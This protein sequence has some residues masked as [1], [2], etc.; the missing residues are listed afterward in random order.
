MM[1]VD[2]NVKGIYALVHHQTEGW[3]RVQRLA[4]SSVPSDALRRAATAPD[5][6]NGNRTPTQRDG[7]RQRE[8]TAA[9]RPAQDMA[10]W[11][12][13]VLFESL[14]AKSQA[15]NGAHF[16]VSIVATNDIFPNGTIDYGVIS[17][18]IVS[19]SRR[20]F[21][22]VNPA[23]NVDI[24]KIN[25]EQV[26]DKDNYYTAS[27][28]TFLDME[29]ANLPPTGA[30]A[31][32]MVRPTNPPDEGKRYLM[33]E[34]LTK[35]GTVTAY[36][37]DDTVKSGAQFEIFGIAMY[38]RDEE[39][40]FRTGVCGRGGKPECLVLSPEEWGKCEG[41]LLAKGSPVQAIKWDS[42]SIDSVD[43]IALID[44]PK[45]E[46]EQPT[47]KHPE[48]TQR[49]PKPAKTVETKKTGDPRASTYYILNRSVSRICGR[50]HRRLSSNNDRDVQLQ[51]N[52]I[53]QGEKIWLLA[54]PL[55]CDA[56]PWVMGWTSDT[57][58]R[59]EWCVL[60]PQMNPA[61]GTGV[62]GAPAASA[63][64]T[65]VRR[66]RA[67]LAAIS[68]TNPLNTIQLETTPDE[69]T[70]DYSAAYSCAPL[71]RS[72]PDRTEEPILVRMQ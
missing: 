6:P 53:K 17:R 27:K 16:E 28:H 15:K 69:I 29:I 61:T 20:Y 66:D 9:R 50:V 23:T 5:Q 58:L 56:D 13:N 67:I 55:P 21:F 46:R 37:G 24:S 12:G 14:D 63:A 65:A 51:T 34:R 38:E 25:S 19:Q 71:W 11:S 10:W 57:N 42:L 7:R 22:F 2:P 68:E 4:Y 49:K 41:V 33:H 43:T 8:Q 3:W 44:L 72:L 36:I 48:K 1:R 26:T 18:L 31:G 45:V 40:C 39:T 32:I 35:S 64:G 54:F 59:G 70:A 60:A 62:D 52:E 30:F 47:R